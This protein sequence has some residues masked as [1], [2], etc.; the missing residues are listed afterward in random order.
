MV[1]NVCHVQILILIVNYVLITLSV[2]N[3]K[4]PMFRHYLIQ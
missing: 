2:P 3:A 4:I 1:D